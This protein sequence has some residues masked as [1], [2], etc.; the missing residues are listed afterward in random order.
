MINA[1]L[2]Q[3]VET[4]T[5]LLIES[6]LKL[7]NAIQPCSDNAYN[8]LVLVGTRGLFRADVDRDGS[9]RVVANR[10]GHAGHLA[11][12]LCSWF[13]SVEHCRTRYGTNVVRT[14][15]LPIFCGGC[16]AFH[17]LFHGEISTIDAAGVWHRHSIDTIDCARH[18]DMIVSGDHVRLLEKTYD[19]TASWRLLKP[20]LA[21]GV[22]RTDDDPPAE[23]V[24]PAVPLTPLVASAEEGASEVPA[25]DTDMQLAPA[26]SAQ[27]AEPVAATAETLLEVD[28]EMDLMPVVPH[29]DPCCIDM[30]YVPNDTP[31]PAEQVLDEAPVVRTK[32][33]AS[34]PP[35]EE[36]EA[37]AAR[38]KRQ[39]LDEECAAMDAARRALA[40]EREQMVIERAKIEALMAQL[41]LLTAPAAVAVQATAADDSTGSV[42]HE[43]CA[44]LGV[45]VPVSSADV[46]DQPAADVSD[47][48]LQ[49]DLPQSE[50][51]DASPL[52]DVPMAACVPEHADYAA[53]HYS[54]YGVHGNCSPP[55]LYPV[56]LDDNGM[57]YVCWLPSPML[58]DDDLAQDAHVASSHFCS[59]L[60]VEDDF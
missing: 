42:F 33:C 55:T 8:S 48:P 11:E 25:T 10:K 30:L 39:R 60:L 45:S 18:T 52:A 23:G 35:A 43:T 32:R 36:E 49:V 13:S 14:F 46:S 22:L 37:G 29:D 5:N 57:P 26:P 56:Q 54:R 44:A 38:A 34:P 2:Q 28:T 16:S 3:Y 12:S 7:Y 51:T 47:R 6:L 4:N 40:A 24:L 31:H 1:Q 19:R 50:A 58:S 9:R 41:T 17:L 59:S 27:S 15:V 21:K 53:Y 20:F